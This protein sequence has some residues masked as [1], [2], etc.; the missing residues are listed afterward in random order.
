[1]V[2]LLGGINLLEFLSMRA[3]TS[4]LVAAVLEESID[5]RSSNCAQCFADVLRELLRLARR[6]RAGGP[7]ADALEVLTS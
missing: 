5:I 1:M 2:G 7:M 6:L 3:I 4:R